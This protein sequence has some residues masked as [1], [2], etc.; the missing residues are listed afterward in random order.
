MNLLLIIIKLVETPGGDVLCSV[1]S[2]GKSVTVNMGTVSFESSKIP[3][4]GN[5]REVFNEE[6]TIN[7]KTLKYCAATIGN[8]HCA[9]CLCR[10]RRLILPDSL[11]L[12]LRLIPDFQTK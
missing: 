10:N 2:D 9:L 12:T 11:G 8:P 6:I 5:P 3:V 4:T 7:G 1:R